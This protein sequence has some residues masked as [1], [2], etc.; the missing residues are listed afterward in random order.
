ME[1]AITN[2]RDEGPFENLARDHPG[3]NPPPPRYPIRSKFW[4]PELTVAAEN[5]PVSRAF[6][7]PGRPSF[8]TSF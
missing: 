8:R 4:A 3:F 7:M 2:A 1:P 6:L 5:R